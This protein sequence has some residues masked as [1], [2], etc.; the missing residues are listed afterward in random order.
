MSSLQRSSSSDWKALPRWQK[1]VAGISVGLF[2][3]AAIAYWQGQPDVKRCVDS[4]NLT[5]CFLF[6]QSFWQ[7]LELLGVPLSLAILGYLLQR[8][9]QQRA[10]AEAKQQREIAADEE[11]EEILQTY[12][13]RLSTLLV[14]KNLLSLATRKYGY[15]NTHEGL[16]LSGL[17]ERTSDNRE[18]LSR[19]ETEVLAASVDVIRART[20][21]ILRRFDGDADR[22]ASVMQFLIEA[23]VL[24]KAKLSLHDADLSKAY[25]YRAHLRKVDLGRANLSGAVLEAANLSAANLGFADL[26]GATLTAANLC[27]ATL[28]AADLRMTELRKA[29]LRWSK[30]GGSNL[31]EANLSGAILQGAKLTATNLSHANFQR[32][33]LTNADLSGADLS[34]A[35][36]SHASLSGANL[37]GAD[38]TGATVEAHT[39]KGAKLDSATL[40][41]SGL[42]LDDIEA[43]SS[44]QRD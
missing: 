23:D 34:G 13:D 12:F 26:N 11:R 27:N 43:A 41:P 16:T 15:D 29:D 28:I 2:I 1:G 14:D 8:K 40:L 6:G 39:L 10:K 5:Q 38:L 18:P 22:K 17:H 9:Q 21:S 3:A 33:N 4:L 36:L 20:L 19:D 35:N 24:S 7:W 30:F 37:S 25:L 31:F 44:P 32:A 42:S